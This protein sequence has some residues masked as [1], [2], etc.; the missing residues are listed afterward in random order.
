[1]AIA[2][3]EC[4][5]SVPWRVA[6]QLTPDLSLCCY[7]TGQKS[8]SALGRPQISSPHGSDKFVHCC[9]LLIHTE[10]REIREIRG[11]K[12]KLFIHG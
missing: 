4:L 5:W 1:M 11:S 10:I 8:V 2:F 9:L 3:K 12:T 7:S 6:L